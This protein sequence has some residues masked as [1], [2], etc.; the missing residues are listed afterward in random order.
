[1]NAMTNR[2]TALALMAHPDDAEF[3]CAGTLALLRQQGWAIHIATLTAGDCGS[4][5][6]GPEEISRIRRGEA[7]QA[8]AVLDGTYHCLECLDGF[9]AYDRPTLLK[10]IGLVRAV[11]PAVV[12]T[13][14]PQDYLIDHEV[15]SGIMI[16]PG[17][18]PSAADYGG[19]TGSRRR[20]TKA[21]CSAGR[22]IGCPSWKRRWMSSS[23]AKCPTCSDA[24]VG[25][26]AAF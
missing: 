22:T 26:S 4:E 8:A 10:V 11:R 14:S 12:F 13:H 9:I 17:N 15:T 19:R 7:A 18:W 1:M 5:H 3:A 25:S 23:F 16:A 6:L 2:K 21:N 20:A 24:T